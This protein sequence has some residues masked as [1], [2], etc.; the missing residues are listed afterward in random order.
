MRKWILKAIIQ[1]GISFLPYKNKINYFFQKHITKGV[2]LSDDLFEDRLIHA[3]NHIS[4]FLKTSPDS[5]G[6]ISLELG[7]GWYP[8]VPISMY[9]A[10][11]KSIYSIDI[12]NLTSVK[13]QRDSILKFME[14]H[15]NNKIQKYLPDL[16]LDRLST[17]ADLTTIKDGHKFSEKWKSLGFNFMVK[18]ARHLPFG[19]A[20][21]D[22]IH[23]NNTLEHVYPNVLND[24]FKEFYRILKHDG[25]MSHFID[26]S[27]H[28][29]HLDRSISIYNFL[30]FTESQ[31]KLI[32]NSVQPQN[33]WRINDYRRLYTENKFNILEELNRKGEIDEVQKL[34]IKPPFSLY[35]VSDI[36]ISHTHIYAKKE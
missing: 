8:I 35:S 5:S 26:M 28:F 7:T 17:L 23:S 4:Y 1:K 6:F 27:D 29:A 36:A 22:L 16:N 19:D 24:L 11:A 30:Q 14:W 18:D 31:W 33:R 21:I 9:L 15:K 13:M 34:Q 20:Y 32:D 2:V 3:S 10:G 12:E 25:L